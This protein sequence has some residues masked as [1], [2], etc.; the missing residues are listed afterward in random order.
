MACISEVQGENL[1]YKFWQQQLFHY[2][3][4]RMPMVAKLSETEKQVIFKEDTKKTVAIL[5]HEFVE[6]SVQT[7]H[8]TFDTSHALSKSLLK[9]SGFKSVMKEF[10]RED[11]YLDTLSHQRSMY[12][13]RYVMTPRRGYGS[14]SVSRQFGKA[15]Y[16]HFKLAFAPNL[17]QLFLG[18][19]LV[20]IEE[21]PD[22]MAKVTIENETS[23]N[24]LFLHIPSKTQKPNIF[25]S[26]Y[27]KFTLLIRLSD[28]S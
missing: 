28:Y 4:K 12:Q 26:V 2:A 10:L 21:L 27:Q 14:G 22:G 17:A 7:Q 1:F 9:S 3:E 11:K 15:I 5:L 18:S 23:R 19:Y 6:P 24:S 20:D 13:F 8:R 16:E 25:G